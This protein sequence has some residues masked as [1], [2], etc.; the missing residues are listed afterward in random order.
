MMHRI[1]IAFTD[2]IINKESKTTK[3]L[4]THEIMVLVRTK[5]KRKS[6]GG[7]KTNHKAQGIK[8]NIKHT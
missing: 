3:I 1:F 2:N 5:T 8:N 6:C 7:P 4:S